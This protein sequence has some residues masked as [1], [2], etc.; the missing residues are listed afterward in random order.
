M[1]ILCS[2]ETKR[3]LNRYQNSNVIT[4]IRY[5]TKYMNVYY[6]VNTINYKFMTRESHALKTFNI[7]KIS[8]KSAIH[9][10]FFKQL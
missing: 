8:D 2:T 7:I 6:N 3:L 10:F 1:R 5:V 9:F 4:L